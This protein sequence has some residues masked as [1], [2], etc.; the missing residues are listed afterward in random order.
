MT[1]YGLLKLCSN[2]LPQLRLLQLGKYVCVKHK[3]KEGLDILAEQLILR[4]AEVTQAF[5]GSDSAG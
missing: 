4:V 1:V 2:S 3:Q 5:R